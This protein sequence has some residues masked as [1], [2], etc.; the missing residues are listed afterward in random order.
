MT[1]IECVIF[2]LGNTLFEDGKSIEEASALRFDKLRDLG[3]EVS[4][5]E[6]DDA[7]E[8][9]SPRFEE[10]FA[11]DY[12]RLEYG[13][14]MEAV[15]EE[16]G[17]EYSEDDAKLLDKVFWEERVKNRTKKDGADEIINYC[18]DKGLNVG[19]ISNANQI[20]LKSALN[21]LKAGKEEF[22]EILYSTDIEAE[23]STLEPFQIFLESTDLEPEE[24]LMVGDRKDEDIV[25]RKLGMKTVLIRNGREEVKEGETPHHKIDD[26]K[27]LK[28]IIDQYL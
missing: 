25:A 15:F 3:Y 27:E 22:T 23:K 6:Y 14:F 8:N 9:I 4:K 18:M 5:E 2:D 17:I 28:D 11:G 19:I 13:H 16:L 24:C 12:R 21:S 10:E 1:K 26:L 7:I 20:L